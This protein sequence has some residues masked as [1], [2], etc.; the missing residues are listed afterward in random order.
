MDPKQ[1]LTKAQLFLSNN[2][3]QICT[4]VGV[5]GVVTTTVMAVKATPKACYLI[6]LAVEQKIGQDEDIDY[7]GLSPYNVGEE[8]RILGLVDT[9]K[10]VWKCYIPTAIIGSLTIA[11]FIAAYKNGS[12]KQAAIAS[13]YSLAEKTLKDYQEKVT[14]IVGEDK[15]KEIRDAVAKKYLDQT[16]LEEIIPFGNGVHLCYDSISGRY[17]KSD[18]ETV[19]AKVNDFN[20][21]LN[22]DYYADLN[23]WY[24]ILELP[25][26]GIGHQLG[27]NANSLMDITFSSQIAPNGEPCIVLDYGNRLPTPYYRDGSW[28]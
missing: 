14:E 25:S 1:L 7:C 3:Q 21:E 10:A 11:C 26:V 27:W 16:S 28:A 19:R 8:V 15:E 9:V 23:Y 6:D 18:V 20:H 2:S 24:I 22:E 12:A 4:G 13:A 17:F 5:V